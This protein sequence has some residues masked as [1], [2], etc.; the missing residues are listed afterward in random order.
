M[1]RVSMLAVVAVAVWTTLGVGVAFAGSPLEKRVEKLENKVEA[2]ET[3]AAASESKIAALEA[4]LDGV[5]RIESGIAGKPT[6]QF[7]GVNVQIVN[8]EGKTESRNGEGNLVI[9][10]DE[11]PGEQTGSHNLVLGVAQKFTSYGGIVAGLNNKIVGPFAS[12]GSGGFNTASGEGSS[13]SGGTLNTASGFSA[14]VSGGLANT[15]SGEGSSI[16]AGESN[17]ASGELSSVSGGD[18]NKAEGPFSSIFG[19][20]LLET[21][22]IFEAKP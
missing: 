17:T 19:G 5:T 10:Y 8:G 22:S 11:V 20:H 3:K 18:E 12:V 7:S 4:T 16:S 13:V 15:A 1:K 9:G 14:S 6:I 2:L 21:T